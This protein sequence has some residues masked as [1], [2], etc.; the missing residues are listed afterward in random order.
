MVSRPVVGA[1]SNDKPNNTG[2][3]SYAATAWA[4]MALARAVPKS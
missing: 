3:I 4:T 1:P 2:P